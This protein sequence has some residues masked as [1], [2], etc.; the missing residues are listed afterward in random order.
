MLRLIPES[1]N[2]DLYAY[3]VFGVSK[4]KELCWNPA[5]WRESKARVSGITEQRF[6]EAALREFF[7]LYW[8]G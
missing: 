5:G 1:I 3:G 6:F 8:E 2:A 4:V 7:A